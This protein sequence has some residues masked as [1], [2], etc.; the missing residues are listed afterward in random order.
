MKLE[1]SAGVPSSGD[2]FVRSDLTLGGR[3]ASD[4][5]DVGGHYNLDRC[6]VYIGPNTLK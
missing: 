4:L 5:V 1:C 6:S 2:Q 3:L